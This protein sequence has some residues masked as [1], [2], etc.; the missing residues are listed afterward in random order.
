VDGIYGAIGRNK[1][2]IQHIDD[3]TLEIQYMCYLVSLGLQY[4]QEFDAKLL[5]GFNWLRASC[6]GKGNEYSD[7]MQSGNFRNYPLFT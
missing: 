7:S 5:T 2:Y 3:K 4:F 1:E 6:C